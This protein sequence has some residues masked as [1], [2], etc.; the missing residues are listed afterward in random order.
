[1]NFMYVNPCRRNSDGCYAKSPNRLLIHH[2]FQVI[3]SPQVK[4]IMD[5][6]L[7]SLEYIGL[8]KV[9]NSI[10]FVENN[11]LCFINL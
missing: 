2:Q 3:I 6:Y 1:M 7:E 4:N 11:S 10:L 8:S 9:D 5:L